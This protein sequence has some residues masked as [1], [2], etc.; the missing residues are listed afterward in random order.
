MSGILCP[1]PGTAVQLHPNPPLSRWLSFP[2]AA[3][4]VA[5]AQVKDND[6]DPKYRIQNCA[7]ASHE[8]LAAPPAAPAHH[9]F[10]P[11]H[12]LPATHLQRGAHEEVLLLEAQLLALGGGVVGVQHGADALGALA[13]QHGLKEY[14]GRGV[15]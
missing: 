4:T 12:A 6:D 11:T 1:R 9:P 15:G 8:R 14:R 3:F 13:L 10:F 5:A 7:L 2:F